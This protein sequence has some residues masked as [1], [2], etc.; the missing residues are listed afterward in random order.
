LIGHTDD[1]GRPL[2]LAR[3]LQDYF[4]ERERRVIVEAL[5]LLQRL[6]E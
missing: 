2:L 3:A 4:S 6:T 5:S 1:G